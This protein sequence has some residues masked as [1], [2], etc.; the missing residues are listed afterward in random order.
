[1]PD[2]KTDFFNSTISESRNENGVKKLLS[3]HVEEFLDMDNPLIEEVSNLLSKIYK[4][5]K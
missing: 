2:N 3:N 5:Q 1:M 4:P